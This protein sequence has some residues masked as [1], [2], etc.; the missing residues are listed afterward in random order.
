MNFLDKND[1]RNSLSYKFSFAGNGNG[2]FLIGTIANFY[3]NKGLV[4]LIEAAR[5]LNSDNL[6]FVVIGDGAERQKLEEM[7]KKYNLENNFLL[8]G[9]MADAHKYLKAFDLFVLPSIKEGMPWTVLEAMAAGLP[10]VAAKVGGVPEM[11]ENGKSG[12]L[13]EPQNPQELVAAIKKIIADDNLRKF[14]GDNALIAVKEKF[15]LA[16]MLEKTKELF[17]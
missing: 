7:I 2:R 14:L 6:M 15:F 3:L 17:N 5:I 4:Y 11:I 1:A 13:V 9:S 10:I 8:Q 16:E 12:I